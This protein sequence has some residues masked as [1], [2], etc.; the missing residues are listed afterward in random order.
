[1]K[2]RAFRSCLSL[3]LTLALL[4]SVLSIPA[5]AAGSNEIPVYLDGQRLVFDQP[6]VAINNRTLV[7]LR[8][9]FEGLGATVD[10]NGEKQTILAT[11]GNTAIMLQ[12][13]VPSMAKQVGNGAIQYIE[14]DVAPMAMNNRTLVPVRAISEAF[15]CQVTWDAATNRVDISTSCLLYTSPSPR[16]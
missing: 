6:P 14:L 11:R 3:L 8:A 10:W 2:K 12:L 16:D 5:A 15:E 9:I 4:L 7:P 13:G 1:M